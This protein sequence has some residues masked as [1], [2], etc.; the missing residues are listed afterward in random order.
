M[1]QLNDA[2]IACAPT[3]CLFLSNRHPHK[4]TDTI[5]SPPG[6][7]VTHRMRRHS[8]TAVEEKGGGGFTFYHHACPRASALPTFFKTRV[9][10]V[11]CRRAC[12]GGAGTERTQKRCGQADANAQ[13]RIC[14]STIKT[15]RIRVNV[16][17]SF[18]PC[19][20]DPLGL[21]SRSKL[22]APTSSKQ[23]SGAGN[24]RSNEKQKEG[25]QKRK[26]CCSLF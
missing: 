23:A 20:V 24:A 19:R 10:A 25:S 3:I 22:R 13:G 26:K 17:F 15:R 4:Q 9:S 7:W 12:R 1:K 16:C 21:V 8:C 2:C 11:C 5:T 6:L 14:E 18:P